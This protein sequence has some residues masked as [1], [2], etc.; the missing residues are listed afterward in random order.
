MQPFKL[1]LQDRKHYLL[2]LNM[3]PVITLFANRKFNNSLKI[4][5]SVQSLLDS[6]G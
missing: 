5:A 6:P 4:L 3:G 2:R 1:T